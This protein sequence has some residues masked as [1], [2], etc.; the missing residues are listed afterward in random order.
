MWGN[1]LNQQK[2]AFLNAIKSEE[3]AKIYEEFMKKE[4]NIHP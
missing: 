1:L 4:R 2:I 3:T